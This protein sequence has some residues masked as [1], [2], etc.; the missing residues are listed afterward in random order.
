MKCNDGL[1]ALKHLV[2]VL[3]LNIMLARGKSNCYVQS[4]MVHV[5]N[6]FHSK[7]H[8]L[9]PYKMLK[10]HF[11][12]FNEEPG[13]ISFSVLSR[14]VL[15]KSVKNSV[16]LMNDRYKA[17]SR[18]RQIDA[19]FQTDNASQYHTDSN[20]RKSYSAEDEMVLAT[21][22]WFATRIREIKDGQLTI[23]SR[24]PAALKSK[25]QAAMHQVPSD[26]EHPLWMSDERLEAGWD[27]NM[28][29]AADKFRETTF[30]QT[31]CK[32]HWP[33][34]HISPLAAAQQLQAQRLQAQAQAKADELAE[35]P[36][37]SRVV[38]SDEADS[39]SD[40]SEQQEESEDEDRL[41]S[42]SSQRQATPPPAPKRP[43]AAKPDGYQRE[44][45]TGGDYLSQGTWSAWGRGHGEVLPEGSKRNRSRKQPL[46]GPEA[47]MVNLTDSPPSKKDKKK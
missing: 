10:D 6:L 15:G 14:T 41:C 11:A 16:S 8:D 12:V 45:S 33:E 3:H 18:M 20:W 37:N 22:G 35:K 31:N 38:S 34:F 23:Y 7:K 30:G 1:L 32:K 46:R 40:E 13:E 28:S 26:R 21:G 25:V 9:P 36:V 24:S 39:H 47:F 29:S 44:P 42:S 27:M 19:N 2:L 43:V 5:M 4:I 17:I